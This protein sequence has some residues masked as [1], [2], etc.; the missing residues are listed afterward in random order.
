MLAVPLVPL[1]AV[2]CVAVCAALVVGG[3]VSVLWCVAWSRLNRSSNA[4]DHD[5]ERDEPTLKLAVA[6]TPESE[7][8]QRD[9]REMTLAT[10]A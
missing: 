7:P 10:A 5:V 4:A 9:E 3:P 1:A 8:F 6:T 2:A